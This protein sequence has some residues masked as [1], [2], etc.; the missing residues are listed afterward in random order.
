MVDIGLNPFYNSLGLNKNNYNLN[1]ILINSL[2]EGLIEVKKIKQCIYEGFK[3]QLLVYNN[4]KYTSVLK[5]VPITVKSTSVLPLDEELAD[6]I[7]PKYI[8][9][10][11]YMLSQIRNKSAFEFIASGFISVMDNFVEVDLTLLKCS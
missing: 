6:Q 3:C 2:P 9:C 7:Y 11:S 8:V 1:N 5:S 10:D 4:N